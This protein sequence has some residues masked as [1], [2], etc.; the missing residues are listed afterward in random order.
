MFV[1]FVLFNDFA[2]LH[3]IKK[4][5]TTANIIIFFDSSSI[6]EQ[7]SPI[8]PKNN[9]KHVKK[10]EAHDIF[11]ELSNEKSGTDRHFPIYKSEMADWWH[12]IISCHYVI[13]ILSDFFYFWLLNWPVG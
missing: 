2:N 9:K 13:G 3:K 12:F 5:G 7:Q 10:I 8:P 4:S 11:D 6:K 1:F